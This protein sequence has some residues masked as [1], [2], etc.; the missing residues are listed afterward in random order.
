[1]ALGYNVVKEA[2]GLVA[3]RDTISPSRLSDRPLEELSKDELV[4]MLQAHISAA[5]F[6]RLESERPFAQRS[7]QD[8]LDRVVDRVVE[9]EIV[10]SWPLNEA[11][12]QRQAI[13]ATLAAEAP[14]ARL[15]W[16]SWLSLDFLTRTMSSDPAR[17]G[18]RTALLG[19]IWMIA[20]TLVVAFPVGVASAVYL[21]EYAGRSRIQRIIQT[22]I[23]NLAGVPSIIY[24]MLGLAI[25][26]RALGPLT[27]GQIFGVS[28]TN[29]RTILSAGLT[30]ALLILPVIIINAQEAIRAVPGSLREAAFGLGAT[31]WQAVWSHVLPCPAQDPHWH[32]PVPR[33]VGR[34]RLIVVAPRPS[35]FPTSGPFSSSD[36]PIQI[37]SWTSARK[38]KRDIAA[39]AIWCSWRRCSR[40]T[41]PPLCCATATV[42][43]C[44]DHV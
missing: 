8:V 2:F 22:N 39:A 25:F 5:V 7:Q 33:G 20:I 21:E 1:M 23:D 15:E 24:G 41:Q 44:N 10:L 30:M 36:L 3:V 4:A 27:S 13:E 35:L 14:D 17:A 28:D 38:T 31:R 26:V 42:D 6:Q 19:S 9:P 12:L 37:Y 43:G 18:V 11:L 34:R 29:G 40:S 32:D 16:R